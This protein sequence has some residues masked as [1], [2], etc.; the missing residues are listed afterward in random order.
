R[1]KHPNLACKGAVSTTLSS[2]GQTRLR[3]NYSDTLNSKSL[4]SA[5]TINSQAT[6]LIFTNNNADLRSYRTRT[7]PAARRH[8]GRGKR[9]FSCPATSISAI[10]IAIRIWKFRIT[11]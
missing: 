8:L 11:C 6:P 1:T 7:L 9:E 3:S 10:V 4:Y 5:S 2:L